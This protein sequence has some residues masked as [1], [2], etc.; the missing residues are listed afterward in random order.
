M[1]ITRRGFL[2]GAVAGPLGG[3]G[4]YELVDRLTGAPKRPAA[5]PHA[6]L[7]P[8]QHLIDLRTVHSDGVSDDPAI[9]EDVGG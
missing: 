9:C 4:V 3:A 1:R 6:G 5:A 2:G 8:E 7:P